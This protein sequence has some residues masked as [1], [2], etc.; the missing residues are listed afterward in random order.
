MQAYAVLPACSLFY[1]SLPV[2]SGPYVLATNA[3]MPALTYSKQIY[4]SG[5]QSP[6]M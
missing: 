5:P 2:F 6:C 1:L 4:P 3:T